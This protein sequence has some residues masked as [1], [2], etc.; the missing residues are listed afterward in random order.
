MTRPP[1]WSHLTLL[2]PRRVQQNLEQLHGSGVIPEVPTLWQISLGVARM[3]HRILTRPETIGMSATQ[4]VRP[5]LRA[6]ILRFRPLRGPFLLVAG[7]VAPWDLSGLTS[8]RR[9]LVRHMVGTHHDGN[10]F[11]Y[12]L[13]ILSGYP[14]ALEELLA[15]AREVIARDD[16][17]SRWLRDLV[18]Y[19]GYHE[20]LL[21]TVEAAI[22]DGVTLPP[23]EAEDPDISFVA[24][25]DWCLRQPPTP[26]ATWAAWR[27]GE[28]HLESTRTASG[29]ASAAA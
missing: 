9:R 7:S 24:Y 2:A 12:D 19:E 22:R 23:E 5:G 14:G 8:S 13:Q 25:I 29:E 28:W 17:K 6:R 1:L 26:A 21:A 15:E 3:V 16:A 20:H 11:V 27:R 10:Q 18:V 4:P